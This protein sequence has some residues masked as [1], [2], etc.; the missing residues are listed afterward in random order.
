MLI[1][2]SQMSEFLKGLDTSFAAYLEMKGDGDKLNK[3][4]KAKI[5][6]A[7]D[8]QQEQSKGE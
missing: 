1:E 3:F 5:K 4:I 6:E 2:M 8:A 7:K